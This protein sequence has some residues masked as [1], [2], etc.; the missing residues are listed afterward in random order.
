[1]NLSTTS[2][3]IGLH[4]IFN[5][6]TFHLKNSIVQNIFIR[7]S[8]SQKMTRHRPERRAPHDG[9]RIHGGQWLPHAAGMDS[10]LDQMGGVATGGVESVKNLTQIIDKWLDI[11]KDRIIFYDNTRTL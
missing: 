8:Q 5:F 4:Q 3:K 9:L 11:M 1:M 10:Q 6:S 2:W 7:N